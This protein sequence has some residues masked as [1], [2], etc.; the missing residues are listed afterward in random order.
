M[1]CQ[2]CG[3]NQ[4]GFTNVISDEAKKLIDSYKEEAIKVGT[5]AL[6][7]QAILFGIIVY[8]ILDAKI[9]R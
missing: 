9:R 7:A 1:T 3:N 6:I 8:V 4:L 5:Q 2:R